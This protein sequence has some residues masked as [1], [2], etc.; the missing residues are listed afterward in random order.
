MLTGP[1][2][3]GGSRAT[4]DVTPLIDVLLVLLVIF[5]MVAPMLT[6]ALQVEVPGR[7][8]Q[9]LPEGAASPDVVEILADGRLLWN[10][11]AID[12]SALPE[13]LRES[14]AQR[15]GERV[16]FLD[17]QAAVP[18]GAVIEVMDLCR[19]GGAAIIGAI[20]DSAAARP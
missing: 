6:K 17:A 19:R 13:R 2:G 11:Q 8:P 12:R 9:G 14:F 5:I 16:V 10:R 3:L 1:A 20:P 15:E 18:Y 7:A 4:I